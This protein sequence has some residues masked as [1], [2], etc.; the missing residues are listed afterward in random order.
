[1]SEVKKLS[2]LTFAVDYYDEK[3]EHN[4]TDIVRP[5]PFLSQA[6]GGGLMQLV[7]FQ[8]QL[9]KIAVFEVAAIGALICN[10]NAL[11]IIRQMAAILPVV[12]KSTKGIDLD[13]L[14]AAGD[15]LQIGR[16]FF[17]EGYDG[18]SSIP[19]DF[20]PSSIARINQMN[21]T[22]KLV[23]Y[24]KEKMRVAVEVLPSVAGHPPS[25]ELD[26]T[27]QIKVEEPKAAPVTEKTSSKSVAGHPPSTE[28]PKFAPLLEIPAPAV[29]AK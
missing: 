1:M 23:E 17:S 21:F 4:G 2:T 26:E 11:G 5:V 6:D 3:G 7:E 8:E 28:I 10:P 24:S 9:L 29:I 20:T 19:E 18:A 15:Y 22:G 27:L 16:I 12:G 14:L 13:N 25:T